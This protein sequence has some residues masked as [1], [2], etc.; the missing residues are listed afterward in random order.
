MLNDSCLKPSAILREAARLVES[1]EELGGAPLSK[2]R[3][4][5]CGVAS[6]RAA[7]HTSLILRG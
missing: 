3:Q 1:G 5:A 2:W 4:I 6:G 7:T